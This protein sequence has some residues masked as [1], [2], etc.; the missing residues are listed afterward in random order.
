LKVGGYLAVSFPPLNTRPGLENEKVK[1]IAFCEKQGLYL[2]SFEANRLEY[3]MPFFEFNALRAAGIDGVDPFWRLGDFA[4]FRKVEPLKSD[5]P[6]DERKPDLW[7]EIDIDG[8]RIRINSH[9]SG[10]PADPLIAHLV[11]GDILP[12]VSSRDSRRLEANL[13]TSGN[14]IFKVKN[15]ADFIEFTLLYKK[16]G[17]NSL[18]DYKIV[19][20]FLNY[21]IDIESNEYK[22]YIEWIQYEMEGPINADPRK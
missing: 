9:V 3:I 21:I 19:S 11:K 20:E 6:V 5:R 14:R 8:I 4:V 7:Q 22:N 10:S 16:S 15:P 1:W 17:P 12:T 2:E 13:W 18:K